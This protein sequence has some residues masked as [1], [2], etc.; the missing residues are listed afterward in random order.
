ML[1]SQISVRGLFG[2]FDHD[3]PLLN[4]E[5]VTIIHGPNG[6][7][8]TVVLRMIAAIIEGDRTIFERVPF[9]EFSLI[10]SDGTARVIR[11]RVTEGSATEKPHIEL[12]LVIKRADAKEDIV[13]PPS[14]SQIPQSVLR[15]VDRFVPGHSLSGNVWI[16]EAGRSYTLAEITK[17]FPRAA[18]ALPSQYKSLLFNLPEALE[19]FF[20]E[21][22]RLGAEASSRQDHPRAVAT[23]HGYYWMGPEGDIRS[24]SQSL[25]RVA[26]YSAD[27]VQRIRSVLADYAKHSQERDRS[28]PERLVRFVREAHSPVAERDI[29][30]EMTEL[31]HKRQRLISLGLLDSESGLRDLTEED[32]RRAREALTIY[33]RDV[34][35]KL[36]VFDDIAHRMGS[37]MDILRERFKY[38]KLIVDRQQGFRIVSDLGKAIQLEALSSGEQHE[39]IVLYE[40]LFRAPRNGIVLVDEPEISLHVAWQ[41]RFLSDLIGI[42]G[43]TDSYAIVATHSPVIIG[44][45]TDLSVELKG[46]SAARQ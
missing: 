20:V 33:V 6:L 38:K 30:A 4:R 8:K 5:R 26:Q 13:R 22:N 21:T 10:L 37:L 14:P 15:Q 17:K 18:A 24:S 3:I 19:V 43:L 46:P 16:D 2:V 9:R 28:F 1:V 7:G 32:V 29:L 40:L 25:S 11:Q 31:E 44:S 23:E 36:K 35:E 41:S 45:R 34:K 39:L 42:L 27:I 12:D